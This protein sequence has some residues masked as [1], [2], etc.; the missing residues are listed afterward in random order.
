MVSDDPRDI[1]AFE[2]RAITDRLDRIIKLLEAREWPV[3][4]QSED[5]FHI[6]R[7]KSSEGASVLP[8]DARAAYSLIGAERLSAEEIEQTITRLQAELNARLERASHIT[9]DS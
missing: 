3:V 7:P 5:W 1:D 4:T 9:P 2:Y 6:E 8:G